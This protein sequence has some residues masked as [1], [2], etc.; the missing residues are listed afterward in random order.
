MVYLQV[1]LCERFE[2]YIVYK[3]RYINTLPFLSFSY[4]AV[5]FAQ[6]LQH[7]ARHCTHYCFRLRHRNIPSDFQKFPE[8]ISNFPEFSLSFPELK[9]IPEF[10]R[11]SRVVSTLCRDQHR[12]RNRYI[13]YQYI[14]VFGL[15][16]FDNFNFKRPTSNTK[17]CFSVSLSR[18]LLNGN[19]SN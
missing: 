13:T 5:Q 14:M 3:R 16:I 6:T 1:K 7:F 18:N 10:S 12:I 4:T 2:I 15:I 11:F 8:Y 9:K 17:R 19:R